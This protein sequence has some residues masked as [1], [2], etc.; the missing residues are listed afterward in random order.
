[1]YFS[2]D[3]LATYSSLE[4]LFLTIT[5]NFIYTW[6][7]FLF[8]FTYL[9]C[10]FSVFTVASTYTVLLTYNLGV[11][12]QSA[13]PV[14]S[15]VESAADTHTSHAAGL[16]KL[17]RLWRFYNAAYSAAADLAKQ[18]WRKLYSAC[19]LYSTC[20]SRHRQSLSIWTRQFCAGFRSK[21]SEIVDHRRCS[22]GSTSAGQELP[23]TGPSSS[24]S[25]SFH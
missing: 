2:V 23:E 7:H 9:F 1:M 4:R 20:P 17:H 13:L 14:G 16:Y 10:S 8:L 3:Y 19:C 24:S 21:W 15:S 22:G 11:H 6:I 5:F 12:V 18:H 25:S